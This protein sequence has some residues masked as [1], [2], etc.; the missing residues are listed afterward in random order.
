MEYPPR[1]RMAHLP[2]PV[3]KLNKNHEYKGYRIWVKRD[4]LTGLELTGNKARK[5]D[6]LIRDA[7]LSGAGRVITCGGLQSNHCRATAFYAAKTGLKCTLLLRG[8]NPPALEGNFFLYRLLGTEIIFITPEQYKNNLELMEE[9][10]AKSA[11]QTYVIPEGGSNEIGCWGYI[12]AFDEILSQQT[13]LGLEFGAVVTATG[14]GGTHAGLLL[15]RNIHRMQGEIWSVNV[16][17][18]APEFVRRIHGICQSFSQRYHYQLNINE[19]DIHIQDGFIG[20]GYAEIGPAEIEIIRRMAR[21][22]GLILDPAYTSKAFLGLLH[23]LDRQVLPKG[24]VLF[25]HTGGSFGLF[26]AWHQFAD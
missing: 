26:P 6:F 13:D 7:V 3:Q 21:E 11:E 2:T 1:F 10:A 14:S 23:L 15:G 20:P 18:T 22:E 16:A 12:S 25:I 8:E 4:D 9:Q 19:N 5:L 24:P 17:D